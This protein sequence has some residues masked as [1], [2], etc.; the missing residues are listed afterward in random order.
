MRRDEPESGRPC[1]GLLAGC[2]APAAPEGSD[3]SFPPASVKDLPSTAAPSESAPSPTSTPT[4]APAS[5]WAD[6][7]ALGDGIGWDLAI[8]VARGQDAFVAVGMRWCERSRSS[9]SSRA[10]IYES[11]LTATFGTRSHWVRSFVD[12]R[13]VDVIATPDGGF[14]LFGLGDLTNLAWQSADGRNWQALDTNLG[15]DLLIEVVVHGARGYLLAAYDV[16]SSDRSLW[17]SRDG[18]AWQEVQHFPA[19]QNSAV[20]HIGAGDEGFVAIGTR[21]G[22]NGQPDSGVFASADGLTWLEAPQSFGLTAETACFAPVLAPFGGDWIAMIATLDGSATVWSSANGLDWQSVGSI[23]DLGTTPCEPL[24]LTYAGGTLLL[25]PSVAF[26]SLSAVVWSSTDGRAW[27]PW[28]TSGA[29]AVIAAVDSLA[30][31]V[32]VGAAVQGA[33][34]SLASFWFN[35]TSA[36]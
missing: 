6:V 15:A 22:P 28:E 26:H 31:A 29:A 25:S 10:T 36:P 1:G 5:E 7:A 2:A 24:A 34:A 12:A 8:S 32:A 4:A 19:A 11:R 27:E 16:P 9:L 17:H 14:I 23:A 30:G 3:A 13:F 21:P 33:D 20:G 18:V 35:P